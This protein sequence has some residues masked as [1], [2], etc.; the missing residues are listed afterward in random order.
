MRGKS[1]HLR[2]CEAPRYVVGRGTT[3][4]QPDAVKGAGGC[5]RR[6]ASDPARAKACETLRPQR[7]VAQPV[8]P[9]APRVRRSVL[10]TPGTQMDRVAKALTA[11]EADTLVADWEDAV[12]PSDKASAREA[13]R[14]AWAGL[15]VTRTERVIRVNGTQ[16]DWWK[17]DL[18]AAVPLAPDAIML[19]K[20]ER[21]AD[22]A[23]V[24]EAIASLE[25]AAR[26]AP[27]RIRLLPIV[28][29][30]RGAL[31]ALAV[32]EATPR[33][34]ALVFGAED[35]QADVGGR[36]RRDNLDVLWARSQVAAA[37]AA[38]RVAAI[39]QVFTDF[40]DPEGLRAEATFAR[41]LGY[42]G[43]MVIHPK[44]VG[45]VNEVFTPRPEEIAHAR[46]VIEAAERAEKEGRG[47]FAL[48]GK[49]VDRPLVE[50]ARLVL[51]IA[52]AAG[53]A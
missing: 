11:A 9:P 30:A 24:A 50:Q 25:G 4:R 41:E 7:R 47:A 51:E 14:A 5:K 31:S 33:T 15:P 48:D 3:G 35:Y 23:R 10:F 29:S 17:D 46:R 26:L 45:V 44:Q 12:A 28:E 43:K 20:A 37:A 39:D 32:A 13:T 19:P 6:G 53:A 52:K 38:V 16:T 40:N 36:R 21:A 34:V 27:G 1:P 22:V 18:A 8:L 42:R 49:M 2:R